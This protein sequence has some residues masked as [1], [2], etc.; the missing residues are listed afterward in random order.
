MTQTELNF[1]DTN[2]VHALAAAKAAALTAAALT[3]DGGTCNFDAPMLYRKTTPELEEQCREAGLRCWGTT[4]FGQPV[5]IISIGP[6]GQA[7]SRTAAAERFA[8]ELKFQGWTDVG[9]WYQM[10]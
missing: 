1:T 3:S 2:P 9:V 8:E 5:T 6:V 10:D 7:A 4:Q